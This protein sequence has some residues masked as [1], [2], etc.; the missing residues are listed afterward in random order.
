MIFS[1]GDHVEMIKSG[2]KTQTRRQSGFYKVGKTYSIQPGRGKKGIADGRI[3]I[4]GKKGE[5]QFLHW[6][7]SEDAWDEGQ[8]MPLEFERLYRRIYHKWVARYAYTFKFIP[9]AREEVKINE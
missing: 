8:Y 9:S 1:I 6:I 2:Q 5:R 4:T 7:S 3:L